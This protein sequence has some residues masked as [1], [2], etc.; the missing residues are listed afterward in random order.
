MD[1]DED[2][3][4]EKK[5]QN[6]PIIHFH[7]DILAEGLKEKYHKFRKCLIKNQ[8]SLN[9]AL[10]P[11][12]TTHLKANGII[13]SDQQLDK[14]RIS[15]RAI[16][17]LNNPMALSCIPEQEGDSRENWKRNKKKA[18]D[19]RLNKIV[20]QY[21]GGGICTAVDILSHM[22]GSKKAL[23]VS[24]VGDFHNVPKEHKDR[25]NKHVGVF[26]EK[27][28]EIRTK[29]EETKHQKVHIM[30]QI[31]A[32]YDK[33]E[34]DFANGVIGEEDHQKNQ[35][36][37]LRKQALMLKKKKEINNNNNNNIEVVGSELDD[38]DLESDDDDDN[39]HMDNDSSSDD[40]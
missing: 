5:D 28:L 25:L 26:V 12:L 38:S 6:L 27:V 15:T 13:I 17:R 2:K 35:V 3:E 19:V 30:D 37:L 39:E 9:D 11:A 8:K 10:L 16:K 40:D 21:G 24:Y 18:L 32:E 36:S 34:E 20:G 7:F 4:E 33:N 1:V 22:K 29:D 14:V 31:M 23:K